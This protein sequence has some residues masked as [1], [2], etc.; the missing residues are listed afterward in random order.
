MRGALNGDHKQG[1]EK[2]QQKR[3]G[4]REHPDGIR[5]VVARFSQGWALAFHL[6]VVSQYLVFAAAALLII[7]VPQFV[8]SLVI[9]QGSQPFSRMMKRHEK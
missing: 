9:V 5:E 2:D 4:Q 6:K 7:P 3:Q 1:E 8:A